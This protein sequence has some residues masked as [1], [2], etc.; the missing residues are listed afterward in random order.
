[1]SLAVLQ[2]AQQKHQAWL[3][4]QAKIPVRSIPPTKNPKLKKDHSTHPVSFVKDQFGND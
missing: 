4:A 1:M 2:Q 3:D